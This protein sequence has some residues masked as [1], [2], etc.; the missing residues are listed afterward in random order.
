[1][2]NTINDMSDWVLT[3]RAAFGVIVGLVVACVVLALLLAWRA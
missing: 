3:C 2:S 1:M